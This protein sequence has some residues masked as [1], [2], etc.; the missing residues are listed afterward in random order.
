MLRAFRC[1]RYSVEKPLVQSELVADELVV[2]LTELLG[3][4][5]DGAAV[6]V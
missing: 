2:G 1:D 5:D 4:E 3:L 6:P